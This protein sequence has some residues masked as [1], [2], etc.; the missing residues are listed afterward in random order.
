MNVTN[1]KNQNSKKLMITGYHVGYLKDN[2][3]YKKGELIQ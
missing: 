3:I 2:V 1:S